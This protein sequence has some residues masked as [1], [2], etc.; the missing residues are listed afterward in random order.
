MRL[1][2]HIDIPLE[3]VP[4]YFEDEGDL[5][6]NYKL[7]LQAVVC[8]RGSSIDSGHYI[9]LVRAGSSG[10]RR[11]DDLAS[12]TG[13]ESPDVQPDTWL[14][15]DDLAQDRIIQTDI[16]KALLEESPYLLF[17][18]I[19]PV[20]EE[21]VDDVP[22]AYEEA[23]LALSS[24]SLDEKLRGIPESRRTSFEIV[25]WASRRASME[26][27][28]RD[29]Q[30]SRTS[31]SDGRRASIPTISYAPS[32]TMDQIPTEPTTPLEEGKR[33]SFMVSRQTTNKSAKTGLQTFGDLSGKRFSLSMS[34]ITSRL[35]GDKTTNPEIVVDEVSDESPVSQSIPE[36]V[37]SSSPEEQRVK[38][39]PAKAEKEKKKKTFKT[40][41]RRGSGGHG[42]HHGLKKSKED[43][44][45]CILM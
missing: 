4:P 7:V 12:S 24:P 13:S 32:L 16:R 9:S 43:D 36:E 27:N 35:G 15:S 23:E 3:I 41:S 11:S 10:R 39:P 29:G 20:H 6:G 38:S 31:F 28:S 22:P 5:S 25:D 18:R 2:T 40:M 30:E 33:S 34:K 1:D 42:H 45:E 8:H 44:R 19:Q 21:A 37:L 26:R 14:R 17:Y